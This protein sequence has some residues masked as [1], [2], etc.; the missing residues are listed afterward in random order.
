MAFFEFLSIIT[1]EV[2]GG[3][4]PHKILPKFRTAKRKFRYYKE[5]NFEKFFVM[6]LVNRSSVNPSL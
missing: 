1:R 2:P 6:K 4:K 3:W 5:R